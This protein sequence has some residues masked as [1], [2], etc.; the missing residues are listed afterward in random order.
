MTFEH[1]QCHLLHNIQ[2]RN[3]GVITFQSKGPKGWKTCSTNTLAPIIEQFPSYYQIK[4]WWEMD[5]IL[6]V[7][8][9][10]FSET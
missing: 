4:D 1:C 10:C 6:L 8:K 2:I 9:K 7:S 5:N 3:E